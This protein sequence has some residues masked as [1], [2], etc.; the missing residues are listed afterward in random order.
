MPFD[1]AAV[2]RELTEL[3]GRL[4]VPTT[5]LNYS[6]NLKLIEVGLFIRLPQL[7]LRV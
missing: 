2:R 4:E 5:E 1:A 6:P 3:K 7:V